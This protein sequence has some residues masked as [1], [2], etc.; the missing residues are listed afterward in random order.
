MAGRSQVTQIKTHLISRLFLED[1]FHLYKRSS[2]PLRV[3]VEGIPVC[4][5][6]ELSWYN[7]KQNDIF[8]FVPIFARQVQNGEINRANA[9]VIPARKRLEPVQI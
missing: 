3:A 5:A 6:H 4:L 9:D 7:A 1:V 8:K 2:V